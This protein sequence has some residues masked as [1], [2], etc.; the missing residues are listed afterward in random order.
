M[1]LHIKDGEYWRIYRRVYPRETNWSLWW[2]IALCL[3]V[4]FVWNVLWSPW[5]SPIF[6][7]W[8]IIRF[9]WAIRIILSKQNYEQRIQNTLTLL[10]K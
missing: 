2:Y 1:N 6:V 9:L 10:I 7:V 4:I 8:G 5:L 3:F